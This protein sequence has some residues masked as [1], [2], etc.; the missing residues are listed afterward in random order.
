[1]RAAGLLLTLFATIANSNVDA[2]VT[3]SQSTSCVGRSV[4]SALPTSSSLREYIS[5]CFLKMDM[6]HKQE[7]DGHQIYMKY[8]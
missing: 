7:G 3:P 8:I 6:L 2:F 4:T 5:L 1:M